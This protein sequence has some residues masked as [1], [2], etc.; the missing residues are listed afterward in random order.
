MLIARLTS[1]IAKA[2]WLTGRFLSRAGPSASLWSPGVASA[3]YSTLPSNKNGASFQQWYTLDPELEEMLVPRKM[4]ISPLESWLTVQYSLPKEG[5][6]VSVYEQL[7]PD[8]AREYE[9]PPC[10]RGDPEGDLGSQQRHNPVECKNVLKI[11]RRKM[12]HHKYKKLMKRTKFLRRKIKEGRR[13]RKQKRFERDLERIWRG[14]GLEKP[15]EGWVA[16]KIYLRNVK[17]D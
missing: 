8:P 9:L 14:A 13:K 4:S 10:G 11:R 3:R 16:P 6:L 2:S 17:S 12:N 1:Q 5:V 15:P 7:S